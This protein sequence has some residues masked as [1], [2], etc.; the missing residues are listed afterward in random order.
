MIASACLERLP[1]LSTTVFERRLKAF[2]PERGSRGCRGVRRR[3]ANVS[4]ERDELWELVEQLPEEQ[5]PAALSEVRRRLAETRERPWPPALFGRIAPVEL[6]WPSVP[7][8]RSVR[9][10]AIPRDPL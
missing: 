1:R 9:V 5:V 8:S 7:R 10:S 3:L 6:M 2:A 4:A